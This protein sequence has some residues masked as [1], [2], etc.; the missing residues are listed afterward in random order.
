MP[1]PRQN[2]SML[3]KAT[4]VPMIS[5]YCPSLSPAAS[6]PFVPRTSQATRVVHD[7]VDNLNRTEG[8]VGDV[9]VCTLNCMGRES[10]L[11]FA[12][13]G[14]ATGRPRFPRNVNALSTC[15]PGPRCGEAAPE[16]LMRFREP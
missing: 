15:P 4:T 16:T 5:M 2:W 6:C 14:T 11:S 8:Q 1:T 10:R 13:V 7:C 12:A 9:C 3:T